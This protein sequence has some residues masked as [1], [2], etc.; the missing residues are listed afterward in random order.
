MQGNSFLEMRQS[1]KR[2]RKKRGGKEGCSTPT[3]LDYTSCAAKNQATFK[4]A[5]C[6]GV[7]WWIVTY[8]PSL[9]M[10]SA[11]RIRVV[12]YYGRKIRRAI[13]ETSMQRFRSYHAAQ[14]RL[15]MYKSFSYKVNCLFAKPRSGDLPYSQHARKS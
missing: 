11:F 15:S 13:L 7:R 9:R 4:Q 10:G 14:S 6:A 2:E 12:R 3:P 1:K 5:T 8:Y